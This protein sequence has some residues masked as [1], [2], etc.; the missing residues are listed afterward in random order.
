MQIHFTDPWSPAKE[1]TLDIK[2]N[3]SVN[4]SRSL[5]HSMIMKAGSTGQTWSHRIQHPHSED[6]PNEHTPWFQSLCAR[7]I[8]FM[9]KEKSPLAYSHYIKMRPWTPWTPRTMPFFQRVIRQAFWNCS[10]NM[11]WGNFG[12]K[13]GMD[14]LYFPILSA[15]HTAT[16]SPMV[17]SDHFRLN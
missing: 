3:R 11:L 16:L 9:G 8:A 1:P 2:V 5:T 17:T 12:R 14:Q 13:T 4:W 7:Q 10:M 6:R 15:Y